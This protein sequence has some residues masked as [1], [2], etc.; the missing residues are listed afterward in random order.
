MVRRRYYANDMTSIT[1]E[2]LKTMTARAIFLP[3]SCF[4]YW[5]GEPKPIEKWSTYI[6]IIEGGPSDL[7]KRFVL[8]GYGGFHRGGS[9][10][11]L[12]TGCTSKE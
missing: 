10:I 4:L 7:K 3:L 6:K 1:C 2:P 11:F 5:F 8:D 12:R 9:R